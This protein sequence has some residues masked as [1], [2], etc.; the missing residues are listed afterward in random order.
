[1]PIPVGYGALGP[2]H[3]PGTVS[4]ARDAE[5]PFRFVESLYSIGQWIGPHRLTSAKQL[6]WYP[7]SDPVNGRYRLRNDFEPNVYA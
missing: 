1:M 5:T 7:E 2:L 6:L 3:D 4:A